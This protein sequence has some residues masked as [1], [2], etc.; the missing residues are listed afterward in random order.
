MG[1]DVARSAMSFD[2]LPGLRVPSRLPQALLDAYHVAV[3]HLVDGNNLM[4]ALAGVGIDADR[5]E[6]TKL[7]ARVASQARKV[8]VVYDG[9]APPAGGISPGTGL[10]VS[11]SG[12]RSADELIEQLIAADTA[13]RRLS[14]VSTDHRIR[15]AA[16]R[17]RCRIVTSEEFAVALSR[18]GEAKATRRRDEPF[19]KQAG[20]PPR[21]TQEWLREFG[22]K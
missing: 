12:K 20:L 19:E 8:H 17:R 16:H 2:L 10:K 21:S 11:Y 4:H 5:A 13:P 14:V 6:L 15:R 3:S 1:Y 9:P 22:F 18:A 7:L